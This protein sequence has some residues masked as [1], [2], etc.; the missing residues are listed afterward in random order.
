MNKQN[1]SEP[2]RG[3]SVSLWKD[4]FVLHVK[5]TTADAKA[6]VTDEVNY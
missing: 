2:D 5:M 6:N 1:I 3:N 4:E